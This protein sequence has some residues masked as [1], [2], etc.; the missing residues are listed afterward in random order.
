MTDKHHNADTTSAPEGYTVNNRGQA[1]WNER[2]ARKDFVWTVTPNRFLAAEVADLAPG[3]ALDLA[4]GEGRNSVWLAEK[5]WTV[6][7]VDFADVA[8]DK[9]R[10]LAESRQVSARV[11]PLVADLLTYAPEARTY[12]LVVMCYLQLPQDEMGPI[13][14]RAAE[15]VAPGGTLFLVAHDS[16]N[17]EHGHGGPQRPE[18]LYTAEQVVAALD[19]ALEIEK[20][21]RVERPVETDDGV[22]VAL[23]CLVRARRP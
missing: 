3:R 23:D 2:Y 22:K 13:L 6:R 16:E 17:L 9:A 20:A 11:T 1:F 5:G 4:A 14:A 15:A 21:E 18:A 19:G 12:D 10:Q 7:A 8:L